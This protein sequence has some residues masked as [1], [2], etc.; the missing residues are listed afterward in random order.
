MYGF[1]KQNETEVCYHSSMPFFL[2]GEI[3]ENVYCLKYHGVINDQILSF[4][5]HRLKV[6]NIASHE[7]GAIW[8]TLEC[9]KP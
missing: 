1:R 3:I 5:G 8:N 2:N 7:C 9:E 6:Y 4:V